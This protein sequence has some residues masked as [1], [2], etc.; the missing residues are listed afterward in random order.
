MLT[1]KINKKERKNTLIENKGFKVIINL[2]LFFNNRC[3]RL[4]KALPIKKKKT[5]HNT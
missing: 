5:I 3:C 1:K 2:S 4:K